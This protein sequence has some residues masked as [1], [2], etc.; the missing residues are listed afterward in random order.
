VIVNGKSGFLRQAAAGL[1]V[2]VPSLADL[3]Y[4][5][6]KPVVWSN[7]SVE[8][9]QEITILTTK[10]ATVGPLGFSGCEQRSTILAP[11]SAEGSAAAKERVQAHSP[12]LPSVPLPQGAIPD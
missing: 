12:V 9:P 10:G 3:E 11:R 2:E 5:N 1:L 4:V 7:P 8:A 6:S